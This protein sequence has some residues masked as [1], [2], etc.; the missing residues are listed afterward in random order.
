[1]A[2]PFLRRQ[3]PKLKTAHPEREVEANLTLERQ[4]LQSK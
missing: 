4:R 1:M 2:L 3:P